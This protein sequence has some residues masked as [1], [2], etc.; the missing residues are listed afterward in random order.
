MVG[1]AAGDFAEKGIGIFKSAVD[2]NMAGV[3]KGL[4]WADGWLGGGEGMVQSLRL[5]P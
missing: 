4:G 1:E 2:G 3:V 5:L